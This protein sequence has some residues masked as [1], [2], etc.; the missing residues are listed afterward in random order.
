MLSAV[1]L[2][3]NLPSGGLDH[4]RPDATRA[5]FGG[6]AG[7]GAVVY[8][9]FGGLHLFDLKSGRSRPVPVTIAADPPEVRARIVNVGR[10]LRNA[11]ISPNGARA[12]FEARGE[13]LTVPAE[14]G[15]ARNLTDSA[16]AMERDPAWSPDGRA[17]A[18]FS[19]ASG[20]YELHLAPQGG[21]GE[22]TRIAMPR[23]GF[24][25]APQWPPD[26]KKIAFVDSHMQIWYADL[27]AK[28]V[29]PADKE[30]YWNLGNDFVPAWSPDSS[31]RR[32][33]SCSASSP[34]IRPGRSGVPSFRGTGRC[35][36]RPSRRARPMTGRAR[37]LWSPVRIRPGSRRGCNK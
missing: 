33:K 31:K 17:I 18:Y 6:D 3:P 37:A 19:D 11:H 23:P 36:R 25:R 7:P 24:Y 29:L 30:R 2:G 5:S 15:D 34:R 35:R 4:V 13:I 32:S 22:A 21:M 8:E 28:K 14:K 12:V 9:Q 1:T 10:R 16:G 26:S 27:D 20:E